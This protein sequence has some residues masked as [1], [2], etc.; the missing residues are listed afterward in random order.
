MNFQQLRI[1]REA[2]RYKFNITDVANAIYAS[3][4]G[5]SKQIRELEEE[6][7]SPLF[8]RRGK[9]LLGLTDLGANVARM[10]ERV[11][12]E[13]DNIKQA[14]AQFAV[15]DQGILQIAT[16]HTQARYALPGVVVKF[17]ESFP[18]V[19]LDLRQ[20]NPK[21]IAALLLAGE[22]DIGI[23]TDVFAGIDEILTLPFY[24]W[25]HI[26]VAPVGHPLVGRKGVTLEELAQ[27]PIITYDTGITGRP[28][29]DEAFEN[30]NVVPHI[31]MTALDAD[32]IKAYVASGLGIGIVAPMAY[33]AARDVG[34]SVID[35]GE[36]IAP[37]TTSIAIR[38]GRLQRGFVYRFIELCAPHLTEQDIRDGEL[39]TGSDHPKTVD[40]ASALRWNQSAAA[41]A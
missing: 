4:S 27:Y 6:L 41:I 2:I 15:Q 19:R 39:H 35:C 23:A 25:T 16:T 40:R 18:A 33:D 36:P 7:G 37:S 30:A 3:Q 10:A 1:L 8:I 14:A 26:V 20:A 38:R 12:I 29:I 13:A 24:A 9:R 5:V 32:V 11:L 28:R 21:D 22:T 31:T 34:I 17:K